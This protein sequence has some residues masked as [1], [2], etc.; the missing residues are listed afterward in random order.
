MD[1]YFTSVPL[2]SETMHP[3]TSVVPSEWTFAYAIQVL[4]LSQIYLQKMSL[5]GRQKE[6]FIKNQPPWIGCLRFPGEN[7]DFSGLQMKTDEST[8]I[9]IYMKES[10]I[11]IVVS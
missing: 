4:N 5:C 3:F 6:S 9:Y 8:G 1:G 7:S 11:L 10:P 2:E